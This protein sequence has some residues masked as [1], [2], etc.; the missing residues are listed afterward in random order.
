MKAIMYLL[1]ILIGILLAG[2]LFAQDST[3]AQNSDADKDREF[4]DNDNDGY[5]DNAP[6]HDGDGIPNGLDPD[7]RKLQKEKKKGKKNRFVDLDGDGINDNIQN[8][9]T[10]QGEQVQK[11]QQK[12][13]QGQDGSSIENKQQKGQGQRRQGKDE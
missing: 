4:V 12:M 2:N 10:S 11:R 13:Q 1:T 7:W 3:Q 5:N 9:G 6:D 8:A